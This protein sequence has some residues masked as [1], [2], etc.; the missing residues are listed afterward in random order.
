MKI[1]S[2]AVLLTT[3]G[4]TT[5]FASATPAATPPA[6]AAMAFLGAPAPA[7]AAERSVT[8]GADTRFVNV[9]AGTTVR[10]VIGEQSFTWNFQ[11][12]GSHVAPIDLRLMVPAGALDHKVIIYVADDPRYQG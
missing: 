12:G 3:V 1:I 10:F 5:A 11:T 8:I 7:S 4:A 9:T 2:I 6:T